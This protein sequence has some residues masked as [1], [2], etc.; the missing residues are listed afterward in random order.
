MIVIGLTGGIGSGKSTVA[1]FLAEL[2]AKVIETDVIGHEVL[3]HD[4]QVKKE[5]AVVFGSGVLTPAGKIDRKKLAETVFRQ[6]KALAT[7]NKI[8][9]PRITAEVE[10]RL[11]EYREKGTGVVVIEA[12]LLIEVGWDTK[13]DSVWVTTAP[14]DVIVTR[15]IN[16]GM[17]REEAKS[18][19][20]SQVTD[21]ERL[22]HSGTT[23]DTNCSIDELRKRVEGAWRDS[24]QPRRLD[25][26]YH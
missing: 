8:T 20:G 17:T 5:M 6:P 12:P 2:G 7:L 26:W 1:G 22:K 21:D 3:E 14:Q 15:L 19:I 9:H 24:I 13:V 16:K 25:K 11:Q 4:E 18:R 23:I 10:K